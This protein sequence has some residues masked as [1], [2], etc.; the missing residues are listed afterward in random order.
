[1]TPEEAQALIEEAEAAAEAEA[2][3]PVAAPA[4][5]APA[6]EE[7][8]SEL[9]RQVLAV[10]GGT[11]I[12]QKRL[13]AILKGRQV[14]E[15]SQLAHR[16]R[17]A[18]NPLS[19]YDKAAIRESIIDFL[20]SD[21]AGRA[22]EAER[23]AAAAAAAAIEAAEAAAAAE[24]VVAEAPGAPAMADETAA[25][26]GAP[27]PVQTVDSDVARLEAE[28]SYDEGGFNAS[29]RRMG[30]GLS[31]LSRNSSFGEM[32]VP[33]DETELKQQ[34]QGFIKHAQKQVGRTRAGGVCAGAERVGRAVG[35][36]W[37]ERGGVSGVG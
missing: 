5:E 26:A 8:G 4:A 18:I 14:V 23:A 7:P 28:D 9:L 22:L 37:G 12:K 27:S 30:A 36:G 29:V 16:L 3:A 25:I 6:A 17:V 11:D 20:V 2:M 33:T 32:L 15:L 21:Q 24:V 34:K 35:A 10:K 19:V 13:T 31:A 1:M